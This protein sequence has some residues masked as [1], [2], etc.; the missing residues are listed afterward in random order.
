MKRLT[1]YSVLFLAFLQGGL[2]YGQPAPAQQLTPPTEAT[3]S[4]EARAGGAFS[5]N[6]PE[7]RDVAKELRCPTCTGLSVLESDASFSVQIKE[8]VKEQMQLGKD[9][10]EIVD[11]FVARYGAWILRE[12]PKQ[13]FNLLAWLVPSVLLCL[14]PILIWLLVW[15][16]RVPANTQGVRSGE[17]ILLEMQERLNHLK[18]GKT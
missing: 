10:D 16:R 4:A 1:W 17:V 8:Q 3:P 7:F 2:A 12:P 15:K 13:G 6:N 18:Q 9:K 5:D 11:F 14:G